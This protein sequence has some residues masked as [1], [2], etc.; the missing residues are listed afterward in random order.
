MS[1]LTVALNAIHKKK[2]FSCGRDLLDYYLHIQAKQ[3]VK[4]KLSACFILADV[5]NAVKGFYTL[6]S[7]S[8]QRELIPE[9]LKKKLPP[10]YHHLPATL[11]GRLAVAIPYKCQGL[12]ELLLLDALKRSYDIAIGSIGSMA[13]IADPIDESAQKFYEKYG[14]ISLPDSGKMFLPMETIA[15]LFS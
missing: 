14:F 7:S 10:S 13:V 9:D 1:Y 2:E 4:R 5:D 15:A 12:G 11:L 3:D 6:S 8:I